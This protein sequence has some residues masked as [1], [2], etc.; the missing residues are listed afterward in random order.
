MNPALRASAAHVFVDNLDSV[1]V[2][3]DDAHHLFRVLRLRDGERVTVSDGR[4]SW[5]SC[6][7]VD[8]G[9]RSVG[10]VVVEPAGTQLTIAA[11]IPKGDRLEW[12]V[13]KLTE[14]GVSEIVLLNCERSVVRWKDDRAPK[15]LA[16]L[17]RVAR[18]AA[19]QSRRVWLPHL[20]GPVDVATAAGRPGA[21][22][23]DPDGVAGTALADRPSVVLI[24]PEGGFT[25]AERRLCGRSV[26]LGRN[27]LRVET[28]ALYAAVL[29]GDG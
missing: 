13:Q 23:A 20:A 24:G 6:T 7:V 22:V 28:A 18:E 16:R 4:G 19:A 5:Q 15:H 1:S 21:V 8:A 17:A 14:L 9:L 10:E 25:E 11:A 12:M 27:I 3:A 26:G 2:S 29:F